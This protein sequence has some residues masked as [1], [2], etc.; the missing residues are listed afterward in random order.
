M[1]LSDKIKQRFQ[2][3]SPEIKKYIKISL[4][5]IAA[6]LI[7]VIGIIIGRSNA[8]ATM[9]S[10]EKYQEMEKSRDKYINSEA[11]LKEEFDA[12]KAK[13][14]PYES[15][16]IADAENKAEQERLNIEKQK[17][18]QE[19]QKAVAEKAAAEEKAR[20]EAEQKAAAQAKA[21]EEA[22]GYET[23]ITF[24]NLARTPD[25]YVGKKVKFKGKVIQVIEGTSETQLRL[26]VNGSYD[27]VIFCR[28]PK[29]KTSSSRIL[30]D[31]YIHIMGVS[32]GLVSY[33][34]TMGGN[35]TI[36]DISVDDWGQN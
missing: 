7:L 23:G 31:D 4:I 21:A 11:K 25:E 27:K 19:A 36:P 34:S 24:D 26:A 1:T 9:V 15:I 22:K 32:N 30:E 33:Q 6:I 16:Q 35:I 3:L 14:Q 5:A 13:M 29:A 20:K 12:Y 17:Q 18:E 8:G 2:N 28:V 10:I